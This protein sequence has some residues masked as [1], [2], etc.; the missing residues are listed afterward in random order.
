MSDLEVHPESG[1]PGSSRLLP[2]GPI[3]DDDVIDAPAAARLLKVGRN[4]LYDAVARGEIP[5]RR[6]GKLLRFSRSGLLRWLEGEN[7]LSG[8]SRS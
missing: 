5:H 7:T 2:G 6:I 3:G 1:Q 4:A 8:A